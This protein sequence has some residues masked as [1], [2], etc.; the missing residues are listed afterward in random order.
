[1]HFATAPY[2]VPF[3][4]AGGY[5]GAL[6][7]HALLHGSRTRIRAALSHLCAVTHGGARLNLVLG[8][9]SDPRSGRGRDVG[10]GAFAPEDGDETGIPHVYFSESE[11]R[12]ML[13]ALEIDSLDE[14][15]AA[16]TAGRWAHDAASA[17]QMVHWFVRARRPAPGG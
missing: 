10:D 7:T 14:R 13:G 11:V 16:D 4:F 17:A 15:S 1:M 6:S 2:D 8:S 3:P 12:E 5:D 9:R